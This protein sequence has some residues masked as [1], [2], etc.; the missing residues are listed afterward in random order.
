MHKSALK[1]SKGHSAQ[2]QDSAQPQSHSERLWRH[3][4]KGNF[5]RTRSRRVVMTELTEEQ[6]LEI[7]EAYGILVEISRP[8]SG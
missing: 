6:R 8:A 3:N 4:V 7:E 2:P 5:H 1:S